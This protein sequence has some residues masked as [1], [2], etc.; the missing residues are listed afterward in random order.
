MDIDFTPRH[1][2]ILCTICVFM[3]SLSFLYKALKREEDIVE[4]AI[5]TFAAEVFILCMW[6]AVRGLNNL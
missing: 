1:F 5:G 4:L 6:L 3:L 2:T